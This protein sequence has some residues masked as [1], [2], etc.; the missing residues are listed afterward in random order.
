M[1]YTDMRKPLK[2]FRK[3]LRT[4]FTSAHTKRLVPTLWE[5]SEE[6][7]K[8]I[9]DELQEDPDRIINLRDYGRRIMWDSFGLMVLGHD[10]ETLSKPQ[11]DIRTRF[12]QMQPETRAF[13]YGSIILSFV[14][15]RPVLKLLSPI[16]RRSTLKQASNYIREFAQRLVENKQDKIQAEGFSEAQDLDI[17]SIAVGSKAF[18][19][20]DLVDH[21]ML[22]FTAGPNSTSVALDWAIYEL[23][24]R[25]KLQQSLREEIRECVRGADTKATTEIG[26]QLQTLPLLN[27]FISE[28]LRYY[29]FIPLST[30]VAEVDTSILGEPVTKGTVVM[31]PVEAFNR[32]KSIWGPDAES[33]NPDR[34]LGDASGGASTNYAMMTF[35]AGPMACIG[36]NFARAMLACFVAALVLRFDIDVVNR[37]TAGK[38]KPGQFKHSAEGMRARLKIMNR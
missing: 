28:V 29:P 18:E 17:L 37:Q 31:V 33:F 27:A 4:A 21:M 35:G 19:Q 22:F 14:D 13:D 5:K 16:L 30:K 10:F 32:N 2:H 9:E 12:T 23:S 3:H 26:S 1:N 6:M 24:G 25:P 20:D 38:P 11:S 34:W 36:Q 7:I 8:L 15:L